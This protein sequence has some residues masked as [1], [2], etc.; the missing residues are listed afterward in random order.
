MDIK[1][2]SSHHIDVVIHSENGSY[3][4]G[5][6]IYGHPEIDQKQHTWTLMRRLAS[7]SSLPWICY[8]DF[9]EILRMNEKTGK[10]E[11]RV[12]NVNEFREAVNFFGL[13]DMGFK[14]HPFT[15]SNRRFG[16]QLVE[17]R[18]DRF[19]CCKTWGVCFMKQQLNTL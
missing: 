11:R 3:W 12:S 18:L 7:L 4:R 8:G 9:N 14:G 13:R 5:T 2:F 17:E 1:S 6:G 15:W 19:L 16:P 10:N